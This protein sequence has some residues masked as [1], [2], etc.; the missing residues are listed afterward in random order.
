MDFFFFIAKK[1]EEI[2]DSSLCFPSGTRKVLL[3]PKFPV[4]MSLALDYE[5]S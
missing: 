3:M 1:W 5:V 4:N 2:C